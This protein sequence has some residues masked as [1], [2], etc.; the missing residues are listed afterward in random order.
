MSLPTS[1]R[2]V[3]PAF[4]M[5]TLNRLKPNQAT[6][7]AEID[8]IEMYG[9]APYV[10]EIHSAVRTPDNI[11]F[12]GKSAF[13]GNPNAFSPYGNFYSV[14]VDPSG[15]LLHFYRESGT[16]DGQPAGDLQEIFTCP[17]L[18][19]MQQEWYFLADYALN[20]R[21]WTGQPWTTPSDMWVKGFWVWTP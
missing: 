5:T 6:N 21:S 20:D 9:S 18:P 13:I 8:V 19:D 11:Q 10:Q 16:W 7:A 14:W 2:D 1:G 15:G 17:F 4:W 12:G 3:W